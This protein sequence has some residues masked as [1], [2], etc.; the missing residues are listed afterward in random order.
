MRKIFCVRHSYENQ[1][2]VDQWSYPLG[3]SQKYH[4]NTFSYT[5]RRYTWD[6]WDSLVLKV[7]YLFLKCKFKIR[8]G[9]VRRNK[10][11]HYKYIYIYIAI[12]VLVYIKRTAF[13]IKEIGHFY[14]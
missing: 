10:Y 2:S 1:W 7:A 14:K 4:L 6:I 8:K 11:M 12:A 3:F 13:S 5:Q 9:Q